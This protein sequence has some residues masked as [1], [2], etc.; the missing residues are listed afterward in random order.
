[1]GTLMTNIEDLKRHDV[2]CLEDNEWM[3]IR[4]PL[5]D[6]QHPLVQKLD[7]MAQLLTPQANGTLPDIPAS[8]DP[9]TLSLGA[10][11]P[12][13]YQQVYDTRR[14]AFHVTGCS[15]DPLCPGPQDAVIAA[16][17][18]QALDP[19]AEAPIAFFYHLGD[20]AY[21]L[22]DPPPQGNGVDD[23]PPSQE[24]LDARMAAASDQSALYNQEFYQAY[25][26]Y[27]APIFGIAGNHD[28]KYKK[29]K[30]VTPKRLELAQS[31]MWHFL[32]TFCAASAAPSPDDVGLPAAG[33]SPAQPPAGRAT[34][35]QPYPFWILNTPVLS[36]IGL[37][38]NVVNGGLLD[39]PNGQD[40]RAGIQYQWLV[41]RLNSLRAANEEAVNQG[42]PRKPILLA[43]HYPP[44][45]AAENFHLRGDPRLWLPP[46]KD[47]DGSD[48]AP[49]EA[50]PSVEHFKNVQ[51][52]GVVLQQAFADSKQRPDIIVSAHAHLYQQLTYTFANGQEMPCLIVGCGGHAPL[53]MMGQDCPKAD[54]KP[55]KFVPVP[56]TAM[57][58]GEAVPDDLLPDGLRG[59]LQGDRLLLSAYHDGLNSKG[60]PTENHFGFVRVT[61]E[62]GTLRG[63]FF[64]IGSGG[65]PR[66]GFTLILGANVE[67]NRL[68]K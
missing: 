27:P 23:C 50:E 45:S 48:G 30:D 8:A 49:Q 59:N 33:V 54:P 66:D 21:K 56:F 28:G 26:N 35:T 10:V 63:D 18:A 46:K 6:P 38:A 4:H 34:M 2:A 41:S 68:Q 5:L 60:L 36:V 57:S 55:K 61:V 22:D 67:E 14:M 3:P 7:R 64:D 43:I 13:V 32:S 37:Y 25:Q 19:Q 15:G 42:A 47:K 1:M 39:E 9:F 20:I 58:V 40:F 62:E 65:K 17:S 29:Q 12:N 24:V 51:P 16:M 44:Y 53:E 52:L 11:A 31:S